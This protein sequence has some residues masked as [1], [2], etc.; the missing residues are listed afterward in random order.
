VTPCLSNLASKIDGIAALQ[1]DVS[2]EFVNVLKVCVVLA[3]LSYLLLLAVAFTTQRKLLYYPSHVYVPLSEAHAN[4][5]F[6]EVSVRTADGIDL[7]AW[8]A[9]AT[10]KALTIVFFHGNADFLANAAQVA[11]PYIA[12]G[13]GFL[14]TE[15]RGYSGLSGSPTETGLHNDGRAYM[16]ALAARGVD[17]RHIILYGHSLGTGVASQ[18]ALEFKVAGLMLLSPY[19]SIPAL[20]HI[21]FPFL[22]SRLIAR[23][24]FENEKKI[25]NIHVPVLIANGTADEVIPPSQ[26]QELFSL[27]NEPKE[28]HSL[29]GRGHNN[30]FDDFARLSID[31]IS[32]ICD[33]DGQCR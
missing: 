4:S 1:S 22:P 33:M 16:N 24:R 18:L 28:F 13:Y 2:G 12:A 7:K 6:Q 32:R 17:S 5:A 30:S 19:L 29:P 31:W 9:P 25:R 23:D 11:D 14:V 3:V 10:S 27:A 21:H 20:A 26:G 15:Y 8:Y